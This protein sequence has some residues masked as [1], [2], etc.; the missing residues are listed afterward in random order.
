MGWVIYFCATVLICML[1]VPLKDFKRLWPAGVFTLVL[2]CLID[3][4]FI[5]LKA[6]SYSYGNG[7]LL[8]LP[9]LYWLGSFFQG[10][11]LVYFY[12]AAEKRHFPY[13]AMMAGVFLI[14]ELVMLRT[15]YFHYNDW[16]PVK[17]YFLDLSGFSLLLLIMGHFGLT[18]RQAH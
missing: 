3:S 18:G 6:F 14:M 1:L 5:K 7:V 9:V 12:P 15:G 16:N 2:L 4:T 13:V 8:G 11:L 17:S 10:V